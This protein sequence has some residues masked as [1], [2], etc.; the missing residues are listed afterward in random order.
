[1]KSV[2]EV[3]EAEGLIVEITRLDK[4]TEIVVFVQEVVIV[5]SDIL[6]FNIVMSLVQ[7]YKIQDY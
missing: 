4:Y 5:R 6:C 2:T 1:M 7:L 3:V